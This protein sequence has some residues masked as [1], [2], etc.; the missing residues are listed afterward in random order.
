MRLVHDDAGVGVEVSLLK[1]LAQQ[2]AVGHVL[3]QRFFTVLV[4]LVLEADGVAHLLSHLAP[5]LFSHSLCDG[6]SSDAAGL[7][8]MRQ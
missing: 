4:C 3:D 6:H 1:R 5:H 8:H 2:D 7:H